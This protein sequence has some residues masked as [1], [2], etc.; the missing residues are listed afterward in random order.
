M[1]TGA[2][3]LASSATPVL[4]LLPL[5]TRPQPK[6]LPGEL[7][8]VRVGR[9][10]VEERRGQPLVAEEARPVGER[11]RRREDETDLLAPGRE[12]AE[13]QVGAQLGEG[14]EADLVEDEQVEPQQPLLVAARPVA[15][16][17]SNSSLT[18]PAAVRKRTRAPCRQAATPSAAATASG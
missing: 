1:D 14:D 6:A 18:S 12:H 11:H 9:Q 5:R 10:P 8:Q 17:A 16:C 3:F 2:F 4:L 7:E 13:E 15:A